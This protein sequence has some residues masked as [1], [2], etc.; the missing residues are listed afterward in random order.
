[1][2]SLAAGFIVPLGIFAVVLSSPAEAATGINKTINF[3][4]KVTNANGTNVTDGAYPFNFKLYTVASGGT[5]VWSELSKSVSVSNGIFQTALGS[6]T[7]L[8]G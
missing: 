3:Q 4:G 7:A 1:M 5:A 2:V 6:A 8:P